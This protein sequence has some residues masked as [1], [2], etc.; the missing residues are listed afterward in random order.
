MSCVIFWFTRGERKCEINESHQI[1]F[2]N[3]LESLD[4][5]TCPLLIHH[6]KTSL[7]GLIL[8]VGSGCSAFTIH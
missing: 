2:T 4:C 3:F 1:A 7:L 8:S 6:D 5:A